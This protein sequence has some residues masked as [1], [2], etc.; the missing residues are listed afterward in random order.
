MQVEG[1]K[2]KKKGTDTTNTKY[3]NKQPNK[4]Q[5]Q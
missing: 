1:G 2:K 3:K 4:Q 5:R